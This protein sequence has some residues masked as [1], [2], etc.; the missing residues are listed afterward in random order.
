[1][2]KTLLVLLGC[3]AILSL[4]A[5][6][7]KG[8]TGMWDQNYQVSKEYDKA[9]K[10]YPFI[11][12]VS[13]SPVKG[14]TEIHGRIYRTV[15]TLQLRMDVFLP[16]TASKRKRT[17]V[18]FIH[19]GGWRS[20]KPSLHHPLVRKLA[21]KGYVCFTPQY[22]LSTHALFPAAVQDL[23]DAVRWV[24]AHAAQYGIDPN[25]IVAAGHSAGGE[26][27]AF[28]GATNGKPEFEST[29]GSDTAFSKVNA[30]IDLDGTLAFIHPES[31]EGDDSRG[32]SAATYWFGY[33]KTENP[34][35]WIQAAP[36]THVGPSMSPI[37]FIG[38]S[39]KRMQA[40]R[41]DF[42]QVLLEHRFYSQIKDYETAPH[43]FVLF[44]PWMD[45]IVLDMD[46]FL[47]KVF[48]PLPASGR[49]II[50]ATD[51]SGRF[52]TLQEAIRS[53]PLPNKTPVTIL[54]R[55][56]V[57]REK[58]LIDSLQDHI[59]IIGEGPLQTRI[60]WN[61]HPGK[62]DAKGDSINTRS[63]WTFKCQG[64]DFYAQGVTFSNDAGFSAGQAVALE[65]D[66]DRA[67]F[68]NCRFTGF[69][70][71]L[72]TNSENGRQYFEN[73]TIEGTTDFI[74][75]AATA[76]FEQC[77]IYSKKNS[78]VTAASTPQAHAYGYV[79]N[80]CRLTGDDTLSNVSLGRPWRPY[81]SVTYLNC[82]I[83]PHIK[84]EGWSVWNR[85]ENHLT[86]RYSE[87]KNYGPSGSF[88]GRLS[89]VHQLDDATALQLTP[90]FIFKDWDPRK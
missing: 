85:N 5:Q 13:E 45:S 52:R 31:G 86:A 22:R 17:A 14:V 90:L 38:S 53:I 23:K 64:N 6:S 55:K 82:Y 71:V 20:G 58:V 79:F 19:G 56:G 1:M 33:S 83:G 29:E 36:L 43:S 70:D 3:C 49:T 84:A 63:S 34:Q 16:Q 24:R 9:I 62:L 37:L 47:K 87:W 44:N 30:V 27:A 72:F 25:Q 68:K 69:Q 73:C 8:I 51:G 80:R 89:W 67:V 78:H 65:S 40:A 11:R 54:L 42:V 46:R 50:V 4:A 26:L 32:T 81:A 48:A 12:K 77:H 59:R 76:W 10:P 21:Q 41:T 18:L 74:F 7:R 57:Y 28:L 88:S 35:P 60:V 39:V 2:K 75:G 15:D 66:G 61:D